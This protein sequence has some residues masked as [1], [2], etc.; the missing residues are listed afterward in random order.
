[1][2]KNN[3]FTHFTTLLN[4]PYNTRFQYRSLK[5]QLMQQ[6]TVSTKYI[7]TLAGK[8]DWC[9]DELLHGQVRG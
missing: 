4:L 8:L 6:Y 1:M 7:A 9:S 2:M 5:H 3:I